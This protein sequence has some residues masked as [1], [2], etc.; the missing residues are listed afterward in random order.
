[1]QTTRAIP[2][3]AGIAERFG[4]H[5]GRSYVEVFVA[6]GLVTG[7]ESQS[8]VPEGF[9]KIAPEEGVLLWRN[10]TDFRHWLY[11]GARVWTNRIG[12]SPEESGRFRIKADGRTKPVSERRFR[13]L[14]RRGHPEC[15][16][17]FESGSGMVELEGAST[18]NDKRLVVSASGKDRELRALVAYTAIEARAGKANLLQRLLRRLSKPMEAQ[19]RILRA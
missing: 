13:A 4:I 8:L 14:M 1:M 15:R 17:E 10:S 18:Y 5:V 12:I 6:E 7:P 3:Q 11:N 2:A 9:R 16:A 19:A